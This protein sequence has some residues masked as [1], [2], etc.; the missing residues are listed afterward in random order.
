MPA[1]NILKKAIAGHVEILP[2]QAGGDRHVI[3][4]EKAHDIAQRHNISLYDVYL[5]AL[6]MEILPYRY[7][8]N[9]ESITLEDQLTLARSRVCIIGAGGL[10]GQIILLLTRLGVGNLVIV[11]CDLFD[12]TNL[13]RQMLSSMDA[14]GRPKAIVAEEEVAKINPAINV[15]AYNLRLTKNN[16]EEIF[17]GSQVIIDALDNIP[18]RFILETTAK[19]MGTPLVHGAVAGFIGQ[20]MTVFPDDAGMENIYDKNRGPIPPE[21]NPAL[22]LGAPAVTPAIIASFQVMETVKI[23]LHRKEQLRN[24]MLYLDASKSEARKLIL[25]KE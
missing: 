6:E 14:L 2:D 18:D 10:G 5:A 15:T 3:R 25:K 17:Q 9:L 7:I 24:T 13:N 22:K 11:D 8:R 21:K 20:V 1:E 4:E 12:E 16:A 19:K 23:L